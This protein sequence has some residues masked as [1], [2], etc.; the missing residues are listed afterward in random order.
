MHSSDNGRDT[1]PGHL[2]T[3]E[4]LNPGGFRGFLRRLPATAGLIAAN[5]VA[6]LVTVAEARSFTDNYDQSTLFLSTALFGPAVDSGEYWRLVTSSFDHF[7]PWHLFANMW[8]LLILG[9][10]TERAVGS[11]RYLGMYVPSVL[12]GAAAALWITPTALVA[13]ASGGVFGLMGAW[14]VIAIAYRLKP[15]GLLVLIGLNILLSVV[16]PGIS[17]AGHV[18]GL[19]GGALAALVMV[20]APHR[21]MARSSARTRTVVE[22]VGWC[23]VVVALFGLGIF[24]AGL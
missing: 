12:G 19:I 21:L 6:Y 23:L 14:A 17:L 22:W 13:G 8:M 20:I 5:L 18:G 4:P 11:L 24:S 16:V 3:G 7:G 9:L 1:G 10:G 2:H 15:Q